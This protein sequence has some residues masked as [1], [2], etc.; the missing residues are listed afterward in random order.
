MTEKAGTEGGLRR[1]LGTLD[2]AAVVISNVVGTGIFLTPPLI[3]SRAT[4]PLPFLG[5]W[6]LG[7]ALALI[8]AL[9]PHSHAGARA[10][11]HRPADPGVAERGHH[12][13]AGGPGVPYGAGGR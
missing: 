2:G 8:G 5:F 12:R 13:G 7:G 1:R 6:I 11:P 3:A 9:Q 4:S 10:R